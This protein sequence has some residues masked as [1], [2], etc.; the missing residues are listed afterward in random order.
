MTNLTADLDGHHIEGFLPDGRAINVPLISQIVGPLWVGGCRHGVKLPDAFRFVCSLYPWEQYQLGP[1]TERIETR[2]YD[3]ADIPDESQ[4]EYLATV[5]A[6]RLARGEQ[7][8]V[9]CQAGLNRSNLIAA[10]ALTSWLGCDARY[11]INLLRTR[12]SE[13]VLCNQVFERYLLARP[14]ND[15]E[16]AA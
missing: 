1:D 4:L 10:L 12:R 9:H 11:A 3:S 7:T 14:E 2:L 13:L 16:A 15:Q 6:G 8:L 5:V